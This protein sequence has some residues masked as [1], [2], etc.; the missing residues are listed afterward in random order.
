MNKIGGTAS[1]MNL[2]KTEFINDILAQEFYFPS[3]KQDST[4]YMIT[5]NR[6][7]SGI[8]KAKLCR[9]V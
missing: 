6:Y 4:F 5:I 2:E 8:P 3:E 7:N 1:Y 9:N